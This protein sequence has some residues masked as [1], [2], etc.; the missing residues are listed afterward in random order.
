MTAQKFPRARQQ[1]LAETKGLLALARAVSEVSLR[2]ATTELALHKYTRPLVC[3]MLEVGKRKYFWRDRG[4]DW[5]V[6][7]QDNRVAISR[8]KV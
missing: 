6:H 1:T 3:L 5:T 2:P 8:N 4:Y 7:I